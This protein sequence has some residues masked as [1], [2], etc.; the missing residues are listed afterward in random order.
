[1]CQK[2]ARKIIYFVTN[3][4]LK[5]KLNIIFQPD[6]R[7]VS[8]LEKG[9]GGIIVYYNVSISSSATLDSSVITE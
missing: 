1:M 7:D 4:L 8:E 6:H 3:K 9:P 2:R 5:N